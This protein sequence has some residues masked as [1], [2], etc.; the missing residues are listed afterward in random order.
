M[1]ALW[2]RAGHYIFA[3]WFLSFFLSFF[4]LSFF[5]RL[6]SA[7]ADRMSKGRRRPG[8]EPPIFGSWL[9]WPNGW[10]DQDMALGMEVGLGP[11][12]IVLDGTIATEVRRPRP[13]YATIVFDV[14]PATPRKRA[15]PPHPTFGP[16][17]LWP[18]GWMDEDAAW[19][20][21]RP[22]P[23][24][25]CTRRGPSSRERGTA[26]PLFS[27]RVY[28]GHGRPSQL[29]LSSCTNGRP[30]KSQFEL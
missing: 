23:R 13:I 14:D 8:A 1:A 27:A 28:C 15:H 16:C 18:N 29:L 5:P 24:P 6:I 26:A 2:N 9:L 3:L 12:H 4:L 7:A 20:G 21:S 11:V 17:L 30:K 22:R 25:H 19:Y 10:M